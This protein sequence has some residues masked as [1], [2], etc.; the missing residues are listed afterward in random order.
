MYHGSIVER[1]GLDLAVTALGKIRDS[2]PNAELRIYG[3]STAYLE[4]VMDSVRKLE[5]SEAV[6]YMGPKN[7]GKIAEAIGE[8]DVG[9]IPNRRSIFTELNTPTRIF[10]YLSQGKPVIAPRAPGILDYFSSQELVLFELGDV[11]DLA[12]KIAYVSRH[13]EE[14]LRMVER[15]QQVYQEHKWSSERLRFLKL[16]DGLLKRI[17][18]SVTVP[19]RRSVPLV[20]S[21]K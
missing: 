18:C 5:L 4:Q 14:M 12:K 15:G 8:C 19:A 10:E 21:E 3:R 2:L 6:R 13:P 9:I 17:S 20:G 11:D 1:N 7:L 16:V